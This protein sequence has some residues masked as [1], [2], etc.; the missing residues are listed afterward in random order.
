[1]LNTRVGWFMTG[2]HLSL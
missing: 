2:A 1:V